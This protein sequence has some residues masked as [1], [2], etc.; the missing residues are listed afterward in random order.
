[1]NKLCHNNPNIF[2][3][4]LVDLA[5]LSDYGTCLLQSLKTKTMEEK[6]QE[7]NNLGIEECDLV[8]DS[9]F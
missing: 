7:H 4:Y 9:R 6:M 2:S 8:F 5:F 1:M 3:A